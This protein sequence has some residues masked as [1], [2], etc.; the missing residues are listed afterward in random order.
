MPKTTLITGGAG[1]IGTNAAAYYL[2][3]GNKVVV[4]DNLSRA[5]AKQNLNWL[6]KQGGDLVFV[7]GDIRDDKKLLET[8]KKY[9]PDLVLHLAAQ[10]TMVTS[11]ENPREDFEINA[12]GTF[13]LLEAMRNTKSKAAALYSST[14]KVMGELLHIP[15]LEKEKRYDYK[16]IKGVNESFPLDFFG[17]YGWSKGTGDQYFFDYARIFGLN[18]IVFRQS[19]IY[20][21]HQFGIEEQGWLAW[22]CNA[23]LFDKPVT[24]FGNGKQVRDVLYIDDLL[25]AFDL[26]LKN[27]KKT[28][29]K[30]YNVGGG[31]KF[32]LSIWELFEIL[33]KL[34]GKKFN[35][36]FGPWRPGDQK[37]YI[38][39]V[40]KAKK[41]FGWSPTI[42]PKEGVKNLYK[43]IFQNKNLIKKA[44]VFKK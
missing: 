32:S 17:P 25:R 2:K 20:G 6:K 13:N 16:N 35:Y 40:S 19:G 28:R 10:V 36:K 38:S 11:V 24:I 41:D 39:D 5:G 12:L 9:G 7:K 42:S 31:P 15:V 3:K 33:E 44:G 18:T 21:S 30:A 23:L 43:W 29:G 26:A 27:I 8:F 34:A 1:F 14:N 4:Y 22:F 37:V